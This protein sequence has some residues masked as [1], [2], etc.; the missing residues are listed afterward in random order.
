MRSASLSTRAFGH[1][2]DVSNPKDCYFI[3]FVSQLDEYFIESGKLKPTQMIAAMRK[4]GGSPAK[5]YKH[6]T[7]EFCIRDP[8]L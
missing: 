5:V 3:D 6:L 1:N 2:F 8:N 7:P 4:H